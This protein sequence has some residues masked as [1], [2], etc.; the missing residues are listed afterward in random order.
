MIKSDDVSGITTV[1]GPLLGRHVW[2][3]KRGYGTFL[4][5]EFGEPHID[6]REPRTPNSAHSPRVRR[7]LARRLA[8]IRGDWHLFVQ[9][10][11]WTLTTAHGKAASD[12][13]TKLWQPVLDDL[14]GQR[15][16]GAESPARAQLALR[17]DLGATLDISPTDDIENDVWTLHQWGGDIIGCTHTGDLRREAR[18]S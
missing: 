9:F 15:L 17:F 7:M 6:I 13:S 3:A 8:V 2:Q 14:S 16:V 12:G 11:N 1:F 4:T 10:A 5:M 18:G